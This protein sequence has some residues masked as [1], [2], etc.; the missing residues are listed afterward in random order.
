[1]RAIG[2]F[3]EGN[4]E[5]QSLAEQSHL[6]LE[7]CQANGYQALATFLE[8]IQDD[9]GNSGYWQMVEFLKSQGQRSFLMVAVSTLKALGTALPEAARHYFQ[10]TS[11]GVRVM[12]IDDGSDPG[13]SLVKLWSEEQKGKG[14]GQR[15]RAAMRRKAVK[16]EVLGRPPYGYEVGPRRR[17]RIIPEEGSVVRYMFRLYLKDGLGIRRI[18]RRLNEESLRT[19]RGGLWSM[20][21]IRDIL[22]NRAYVGT[23]SRLGV[24][25]PASHA[26]LVSSADFRQ[27]Q[28]RLDNRRPVATTRQAAPF[29]LSGLAYCG[30]CRSKTIGVT[31]RQRWL[32]RKD[33]AEMSAQYR[34]Y[35]CGSKANRSLC[36]YHT[37][38]AEELEEDVRRGLLGEG[39]ISRSA[40]VVGDEDGVL[41]GEEKRRRQLRAKLGRLNRQLDQHMEA[42]ATG[43]VTTEE[44]WKSNLALATQQLRVESALSDVEKQLRQRV[45]K[46]ERRQ[47]RDRA[48]DILRDEWPRLEFAQQQD[49]L[50]ELVDKVIVRDGGVEILVRP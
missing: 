4:D 6:F 30:Y 14:L 2:Y 11:L 36:Q 8:P 10:I 20:V 43:T 31:R 44:A 15:V 23:Y 16:G 22:R 37:R 13:E 1:M 29:L 28:D 21:T 39:G 33:G 3:R 42:A 46:M 32:R 45:S 24:K 19:R 35:Q 5:G 50:R 18:A 47:Q 25:V 41:A 7:F 12:K 9:S 17:L 34:Y 48:L 27:V 40:L 49:L 26:P 38:R